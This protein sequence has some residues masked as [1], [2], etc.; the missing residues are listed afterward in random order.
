M[1]RCGEHLFSEVDSDR[2]V[3]QFG[4]THGEKTCPTSYVQDSEWERTS[5][6]PQVVSSALA[7]TLA[8]QGFRRADLGPGGRDVT[9]LAGSSASLWTDILLDNRAPVVEALA[10]LEGRIGSIRASLEAGDLP[11]IRTAL[12]SA[13][14]LDQGE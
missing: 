13:R 1:L 12:Q 11:S 9:R 2:R 8:A 5:H 6:L 10:A 4:H 14:A 7:A 3:S